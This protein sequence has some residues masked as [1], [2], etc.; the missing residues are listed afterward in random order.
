M[1]YDTMWLDRRREGKERGG[2]HQ[3]GIKINSCRRL[4]VKVQARAFVSLPCHVRLVVSGRVAG[5]SVT[6]IEGLGSLPRLRSRKYGVTSAKWDIKSILWLPIY[7]WG[8]PLANV[9][10]PSHLDRPGTEGDL[11]KCE[12]NSHRRVGDCFGSAN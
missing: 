8:Q 12:I 6:L 5:V 10:Q 9:L 2:S 4:V 7:Q 3:M 11:R 1:E